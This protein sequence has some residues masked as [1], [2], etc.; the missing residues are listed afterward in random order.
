MLHA[1]ILT[2]AVVGCREAPPPTGNVNSSVLVAQS[3]GDIERSLS[4][5]MTTNEIVSRIGIPRL[6]ESGV[7]GGQVWKYDVTPFASDEDRD[8]Q[9]V[10]VV[11]FITNENLAGWGWTYTPT[12]S[13]QPIVQS[14]EKFSLVPSNSSSLSFYAVYDSPV[15][16]G[17][18]VDTPRFPK[19][20]YIPSAPDLTLG[21][22][23]E[24]TLEERKTVQGGSEHSVW[25]FQFI[26]GDGDAK[27]FKVLTAA[28]VS[29]QVAIVLGDEIIAAPTI[30]FPIHNGVFEIELQD[31]LEVEHIRSK[32]NTANQNK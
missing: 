3:K 29:K 19:L 10:R 20:G 27:H 22:L 32:L 31:R 8:Y 26:M 11:L 18:F 15:V 28:N 5:G 13:P 24:F 2:V 4:A 7:G 30:S 14:E 23:V 25:A 21:H 16:S 9:V 17:K 1:I 12:E 6:Q